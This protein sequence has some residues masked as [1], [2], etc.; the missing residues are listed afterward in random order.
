MLVVVGLGASSCSTPQLPQVT[1]PP[2]SETARGIVIIAHGVA[3]S[4]GSWPLRMERSFRGLDAPLERWDFYR[5]EW[6]EA[7]LDRLAA[8]GVGYRLG[9]AIGEQ[10]VQM[11]Y[12]VVHLVGH[13]AG[14]HV[15][16]GAADVLARER[17]SHGDGGGDGRTAPAVFATLIDPFVARSVVQLFWGASRFG[18]NVDFAENY[19]TREDQVPFTNSFLDHAYNV[20]L[21]PILAPPEDAPSNY[22]HM[23]PIDFYTD[24][25]V[26]AP[27][28]IDRSPMALLDDVTAGN[29]RELATV[30]S[31]EFPPGAVVVPGEAAPE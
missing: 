15:V 13:S 16:H 6:R 21:T 20:D 31:R 8:P 10:L 2:Q 3:A 19:V 26:G 30:L 18:T 7:S 14:A 27:A 25:A 23:W 17:S 5:L 22:A 9:V 28:G 24:G 29:A 11:D 4:A 12:E 1:L